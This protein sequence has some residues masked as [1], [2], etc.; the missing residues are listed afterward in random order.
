[1][2]PFGNAGIGLNKRGFF[3]F[4]HYKSSFP[5][6]VGHAPVVPSCV[7]ED[8]NIA[9]LRPFRQLYIR[10][11]FIVLHA[12]ASHQPRLA[13]FERL[14]RP[15]PGITAKDAMRLKEIHRQLGA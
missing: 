13:A 15:G 1:M 2:L 3:Q 9:G 5:E 11:H 6:D 10:G 4:D 12:E 8:Q 14:Q 7:A